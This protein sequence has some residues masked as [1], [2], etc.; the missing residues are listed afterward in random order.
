MT[1]KEQIL[2][3]FEKEFVKETYIGG[4][5]FARQKVRAIR[6]DADPDDILNWLSKAL[7][8]TQQ[9]TIEEVRKEIDKRETKHIKAGF[10]SE[11]YLGAL[12]V[13]RIFLDKL[14]KG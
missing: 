6:G 2:E 13:I 4:G 8:S 9:A 1:N 11:G 10:P 7:D 14:K 3:E 5:T 12:E